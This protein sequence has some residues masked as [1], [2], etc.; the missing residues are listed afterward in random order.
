MLDIASTVPAGACLLRMLMQFHRTPFGTPVGQF[1][2]WASDWIVLPLRRV[3]TAWRRWDLASLFAAYVVKFAQCLLLS[4]FS[5]V[6][7]VRLPGVLAVVPLL[8]LIQL[9]VALFS[10][11]MIVAVLQTWPGAFTVPGIALV[12]RLTDPLLGPLRRW[13]PPFNGVDFTP[14][15]WILGLQI[16]GWVVSG[17]QTA[18]MR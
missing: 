16:L 13:L 7:W 1:V 12:T 18:W 2:L 5:G 15:V 14:V 3:F 17:W 11:L 4:L 6:E 10:G 9:C 8:A